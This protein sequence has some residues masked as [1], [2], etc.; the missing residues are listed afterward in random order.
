MKLQH[1]HK[2]ILIACLGLMIT[3]TY[4]QT[5]DQISTGNNHYVEKS[6]NLGL[7]VLT[8]QSSA[9]DLL[10]VFQNDNANTIDLDGLQISY[11]S[12]VKLTSSASSFEAGGVKSSSAA[13]S[14]QG[15]IE[16]IIPNLINAKVPQYNTFVLNIYDEKGSVDTNACATLSLSKGTITDGSIK[17]INQTAKPSGASGNPVVEIDK[18]DGTIIAKASA[19]WSSNTV[20]NHLTPGKY[21]LRALTYSDGSQVYAGTVTPSQVNVT[22]EHTSAVNVNYKQDAL[23]GALKLATTKKPIELAGYTQLPIVTLANKN[24]PSLSSTAQLNWCSVT[25]VNHLKAGDVYV[26]SANDITDNGYTCSPNFTAATATAQENPSTVSAQ[27]SYTCSK[28]PTATVQVNVADVPEGNNTITAKFDPEAGSKYPSIIVPISIHN[29][30][31]SAQSKGKFVAGQKY[32]VSSTA[33][34]GYTTN[35]SS[36]KI[37]P[38]IGKTTTENIT[39]G[40]QSSKVMLGY[41]MANNPSINYFELAAQHGYNIA[42]TSFIQIKCDTDSDCILQSQYGTGPYG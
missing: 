35:F 1:H 37:V 42:I 22:T 40:K 18:P 3:S 9:N 8:C 28:V 24:T 5:N 14:Y 41:F 31:G 4:G 6:D 11:A 33:I 27:L 38:Q 7:K 17:I 32:N 2:S 12:K 20:I 26:L 16:S 30:S 23:K 21:V 25:A 34:S 19:N 39:Y 36:P 10:A 13:L 29:G 15:G